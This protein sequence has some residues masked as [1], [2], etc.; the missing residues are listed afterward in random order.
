MIC[1]VASQYRTR[2]EYTSNPVSPS[3]KSKYSS[4]CFIS[5]RR[6]SPSTKADGIQQFTEVG[7]RIG[8]RH[9]PE[10][11]NHNVVALLEDPQPQRSKELAAIVQEVDVQKGK[12]SLNAVALPHLLRQ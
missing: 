2:M 10:R 12:R 9:R 11:L 5:V 8:N 6:V 3:P 7:D 1:L 4:D